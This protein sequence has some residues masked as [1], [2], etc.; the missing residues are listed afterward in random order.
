MRSRACWNSSARAAV[1][2]VKSGCGRKLRNLLAQLAQERQQLDALTAQFKQTSAQLLPLSKVNVLLDI[3]QRTLT[4]W[5]DAVK[6]EI[7]DEV[8]ELLLRGSILLALIAVVFGIGEIWRKT[9]FRYVHDARR[10]N[11][12]LLL[13]RVVMWIAIGLI[14]LLT[15]ATQLGSAV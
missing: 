1:Q 3:Y 7:H 9:T 6:H 5:R 15:F 10:R 11:Q 14:V 2:A 8:R 12:F 4:N 13:R